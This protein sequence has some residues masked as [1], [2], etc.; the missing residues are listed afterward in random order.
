E[1][2]FPAPGDTVTVSAQSYSTDLNRADFIWNVDGKVYKRGTGITSITVQ[3]PKTGSMT[4]SVD[5][6]TIDIGT[7]SNSTTI[8]PADVTL[9][10]QSNGYVPPFYGGKALE[11]YGSV[12]RVTAIPEFINASG[13][14]ADPK[15]LIYTWKKNGT[16][17]PGQSGYGHD[18]YIGTQSS[19]VR[20]GDD[21][22]VEVTSADGRA[23]VS[24]ATI[25]PSVPELIL[26]ADSPLYGIEYEKALP[27]TY[28]LTDQEVSVKVEPFYMSTKNPMSGALTFDWTMNG[29][30]VTAFHNKDEITLR[31]TG[32]VG[33]QTDVG[34]TVQNQGKLLQGG[35]AAITIMQ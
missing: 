23:A 17:D 21:I 11:T 22:T 16:V 27:S 7:I 5:V 3:A 13:K 24:T 14:R 20:G 15:T 34:V 12:F 18:V 1:P 26:Y 4:I 32:S 8:S 19:Y 9:L 31:S 2:M 33:G 28:S 25:S 35:Q 6:A 29:A 10:W 30:P